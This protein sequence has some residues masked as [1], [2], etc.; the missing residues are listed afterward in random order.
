[1]CSLL[2][3]SLNYERKEELLLSVLADEFRYGKGRYSD[4]PVVCNIGSLIDY[5]VLFGVSKSLDEIC[6][7][8]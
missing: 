6:V 4:H 1:M 7:H 2:A 5:V 8:I 3:Y